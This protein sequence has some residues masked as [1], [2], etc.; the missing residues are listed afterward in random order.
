MLRK[1]LVIFAVFISAFNFA[2]AVDDKEKIMTREDI[3]IENFHKLFKA[4]PFPKGND[5]E[6]LAI[7]QKYIFG[8]IFVTGNLDIKQRELITVVSL[9]SMQ[10]LPQLKSH[11]NAALNVGNT[12][13]EIREAIYL[14][15]PFIGFPKTLNALSVLNEVFDERN[16]KTP[17]EHQTTIKEKERYSKGYE[18]QNPIYG[19]EIEKSLKGLPG[20]LDKKTAKFLTEV[21]F[22]DFY[23]RGTLDLK[24]KELL[25]L[26]ILISNNASDNT[27]K[28][29]IKGNIKR[30]NSIETIASAIIQAMPYIGFPA[31]IKSLKLLKEE[32]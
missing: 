29:H 5:E 26:I 12:P 14:C 11:I 17:L 28:S 9:S 18:I 7:L 21:C 23:T 1:I 15:A 8:E 10:T 4:E 25:G 32:I 31:G 27:V 19:D 22:G 6:M 13:L 16:I 3:C 24:T 2:S 20:N 30:G